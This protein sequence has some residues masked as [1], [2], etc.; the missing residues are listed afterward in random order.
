MRK[1]WNKRR[2]NQKAV[3]PHR[4]VA[5]D[6]GFSV[7]KPGF[8]SPWGYSAANRTDCQRRA[9]KCTNW[10]LSLVLPGFLITSSCGLRLAAIRRVR[11]LRPI[12]RHKC[13]SF[14]AAFDV[15]RL[16]RG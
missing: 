9:A 11:L 16:A 15:G 6:V 4:L 1:T 2:L 12:L 8:D 13:A 10:H 7:R 5:Q 3:R 14:C